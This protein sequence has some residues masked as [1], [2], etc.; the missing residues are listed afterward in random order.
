M[1]GLIEFQDFVVGRRKVLKQV[2][3][4]LCGIQEHYETFFGEV[5]R[6]KEE[7]LDQLEA[8]VQ[9]RRADLPGWLASGLQSHQPEVVRR[10]EARL[11]VLAKELKAHRDRAE[12][13]RLESLEH[14]GRV[15]AANTTL[16][17]REERLKEQNEDLL[18]RI[19]QHNAT[20]KEMSGGFGFFANVF[21]MRKLREQRLEL[22]AEQETA[23][24]SI[25]AMRNTWARTDARYADAEKQR[26]AEWLAARNAA[27]EAQTRMQ[28]L[29]DSRDRIVYRSTLARAVEAVPDKRPRSG[30][31]DPAC[32]RCEYCNPRAAH[33]CE[34]CGTR[35][36]DDR[37][38]LEGSL[39]EI[40]EAL[41]I[42]VTFSRGM[43]ACQQIIGLVR[44]LISG[45]EAFGESVQDM[46]DT[47]TRYPVGTLE[48]DVPQESKKYGRFFEQIRDGLPTDRHLH[49]VG[50]AQRVDALLEGK[51]TE[52]AIQVYFETMGEELSRQADAQW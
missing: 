33:L 14:E 41:E 15:K 52:E 51:L 26:E 29:A 38:D 45:H 3:E 23:A 19:E 48:I 8:L 32:P 11:A 43:E 16:D 30:K 21:A 22:D 39:A 6:V 36:Q 17:T 34:V 5:S 24:S 20:I 9:Q 44:G 2:E 49:P 10:F 18:A 42:H 35:L 7:E 37:T 47:Q 12:E 1:G 27:A 4:R 28:W 46:L 31:D 50:F 13:L 25:E 40:G